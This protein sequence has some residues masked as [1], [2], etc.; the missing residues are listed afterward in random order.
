[1]QENKGLVGRTMKERELLSQEVSR[2]VL[3]TTPP[4]KDKVDN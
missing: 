4:A 2:R 1:M 3:G